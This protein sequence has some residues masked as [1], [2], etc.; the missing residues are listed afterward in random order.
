MDFAILTAYGTDDLT[1][2][3]AEQ[4]HCRRW[5]LDLSGKLMNMEP[6]NDNEYPH[7]WAIAYSGLCRALH[8]SHLP[9]HKGNPAFSEIVHDPAQAEVPAS[10]AQAFENPTKA[11]DDALSRA[12]QMAL[13]QRDY[14]AT[15]FINME[16]A[17]W[18]AVVHGDFGRARNYHN[19]LASDLRSSGDAASLAYST[20]QASLYG[21]D[22]LLAPLFVGSQAGCS[23]I[24]L[25]SLEET[26]P[27]LSEHGGIRNS[28]RSRAC[29]YLMSEDGPIEKRLQRLSGLRIPELTQRIKGIMKMMPA[30]RRG[31]PIAVRSPATKNAASSTPESE[32]MGG[33]A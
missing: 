5:A 10:T 32:S 33:M 14:S 29:A 8:E 11:A 19:L 24:M 2:N 3:V 22:C 21:I 31:D 16:Y 23:N 28:E 12:I 18:M 6:A 25:A 13:E 4:A 7:R 30:A 1:R 27:L 15:T 20:A 9:G 26:L 17:A